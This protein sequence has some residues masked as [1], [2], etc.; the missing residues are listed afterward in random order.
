[1]YG[2][3]CFDCVARF[4]ERICTVLTSE[5]DTS[6]EINYFDSAKSS[7]P[8]TGFASASLHG[9]EPWL[10]SRKEWKRYINTSR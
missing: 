1:M 6:G 3:G 2:H 10:P 5:K 7:A 8:R 4:V 9:K